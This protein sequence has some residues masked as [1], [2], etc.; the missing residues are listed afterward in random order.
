MGQNV[1]QMGDRSAFKALDQVIPGL[2]G[3]R[4]YIDTLTRSGT[5][6]TATGT[7]DL[8]MIYN[9]LS[10]LI[11]IV[12]AKYPGLTAS[13]VSFTWIDNTSFSWVPSAMP[14]AIAD[15]ATVDA[16]DTYV[17]ARDQSAI[18]FNPSYV[19]IDTSAGSGAGVKLWGRVHQDAVWA[20]LGEYVE[21][22]DTF[23][24]QVFFEDGLNQVKATVDSSSG[25]VKVFAQR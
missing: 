18:M 12:S 7:F 14:S 8:E 24:V 25:D 3:Y 22:T 10:G 21:G 15:G 4:A 5:T 23:P 16:G 6:L 1:V 13:G 20:E 2:R 11:E 17:E 9:D 19:Q